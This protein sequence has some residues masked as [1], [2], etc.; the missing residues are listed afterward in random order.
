MRQLLVARVVLL[1]ALVLNPV[2]IQFASATAGPGG[3]EPAAVDEKTPPYADQAGKN[4]LAFLSEAKRHHDHYV[5]QARRYDKFALAAK[6]LAFIASIAAAVVLVLTAKEWSRR[7]A[8][9]ASVLAAAIPAADQIFKISDT[10]IASWRATVD[11]AALYAKCKDSWELD[12]SIGGGTSES[13]NRSAKA[14]LDQCRMELGSVIGN[15]LEKTVKPIE[16]PK[17]A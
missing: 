8:I 12:A 5:S 10:Q 15:E 9:L 11:V 13:R 14:L 6:V 16:L 2:F 17:P 7:T 1:A 3:P 4:V